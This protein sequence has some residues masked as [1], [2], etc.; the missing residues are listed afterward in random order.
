LNDSTTIRTASISSFQRYLFHHHPTTATP[1]GA[2]LIP[3]LEKIDPALPHIQAVV[4]VPTRELALQTSQVAKELGKHLK[5]EIMVSTGG[6][7]LKVSVAVA[8]AA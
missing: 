1:P 4:L 3:I 7:S 5:V 2:Q 8:V 6:T